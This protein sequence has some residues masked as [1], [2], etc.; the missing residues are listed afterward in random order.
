VPTTEAFR[1]T[2]SIN[3]IV[4]SP[5][6]AVA[7]EAEKLRQRGVDVVDFSIGEPDFS[8]PSHI[9]DAA[10][11][12]IQQ[13]FTKYTAA[14]GIAPLR[15]AIVDWHQS[16]LDSNYEPAECVVTTGG[17]AAIFNA[18]CCLISAGDEVLIPAPYWVSFPDIVKYAGGEPVVVP[19]RAEEGFCLTAAAVER[20]I[21]PRTRLLI[22][23]SPSNPSG[24]VVP[25]TEFEKILGVCRRRDIL[26]MSDECY[27]HFVYEPEKPF[28]I[29]SVRESKPH[30][31]IVG[32]CS[33][34][35][36]MTG[37]RMGYGL[38]PRPLADAM[39]KLQSQSVSNP[40]SIAQYAALAAMRGPLDS[41][42]E[43]LAEYARRRAR[44]LSGVRALA[45]VRCTAPQGAFYIFPDFSARMADRGAAD[46]AALSRLLLERVHL[47]AVPGEAFGAPGYIRFSYATSMERIDEGM[48]RLE[49]FFAA[50]GAAA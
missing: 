35:F 14:A 32:S 10:I 1:L 42:R 45:G 24:A 46:S 8:T 30:L 43:M 11:A 22:V 50:A 31:I 9:K 17:K 25:R 21:T 7:A 36:S 48:R 26:L 19:T 47:A 27:S 2:E 12:A 34:T 38:A 44:I 5:A 37:W 41:A 29:A 15:Q 6:M 33:K 3:R 40:T 4:V 39:M 16:Q 23:N 28:S 13:N 20:A 49:R 18:V